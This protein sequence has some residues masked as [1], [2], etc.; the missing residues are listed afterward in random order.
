M[1]IISG[2]SLE[3]HRN[4]QFS[5]KDVDNDRTNDNCAKRYLG[6]WWYNDCHRV[7]LNGHYFHENETAGFANGIVWHAWKGH[8]E[9]L[10]R[11]SMKMRPA[12][13]TPG[14]TFKDI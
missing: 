10:K 11:V 8:D 3:F 6:A 1:F 9:S 5:T 2:D 13:F 4:M 7:S 14:E 12:G